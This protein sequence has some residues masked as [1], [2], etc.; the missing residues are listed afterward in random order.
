MRS[1][2]TDQGLRAWT[3]MRM[4]GNEPPQSRVAARMAAR[5]ANS[6]RGRVA[7]RAAGSGDGKGRRFQHKPLDRVSS[8]GD[9]WRPCQ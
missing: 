1:H 6:P 2:I 9:D 8:V 4:A 5:A 3:P 7:L